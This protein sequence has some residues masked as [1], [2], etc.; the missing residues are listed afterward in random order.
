MSFVLG[1]GFS[2][3]AGADVA[4]EQS[5]LYTGFIPRSVLRRVVATEWIDGA[6][7]VLTCHIIAAGLVTR[8]T[9]IADWSFKASH[10]Q[11]A[12]S[13]VRVTETPE[14]DLVA[15]AGADECSH[16]RSEIEETEA[17]IVAGHLTI[18]SYGA[19]TAFV[20]YQG[21]VPE[22]LITSTDRQ[23][24]ITCCSVIEPHIGP[25]Q[26]VTQILIEK[27]LAARCGNGVGGGVGGVE[28]RVAVENLNGAFAH[29]VHRVAR[30][31]TPGAQQK[32]EVEGPDGA[33]TVEVG[34]AG[35]FRIAR[36]A[37][38]GA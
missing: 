19:F 21:R 8:R 37:R 16:T 4:P 15:G 23:Q 9:T 12:R 33:V 2:A 34:S 32:R 17:V 7:D 1:R 25:R 20:E 5:L 18:R 31:G 6:Y 14:A 38:I 11:R 24:P 36:L 26:L 35:A 29:V 22:G 13:F 30:A 28:V 10:G 27:E 3:A